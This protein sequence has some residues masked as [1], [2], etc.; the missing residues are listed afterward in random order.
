MKIS[1]RKIFLSFAL[2]AILC[3]AMI[4]SS[5]G[6]KKTEYIRIDSF[7]VGYL[8]ESAYNY[9][10]YEE[11]AI[12]SMIDLTDG[13]NG[14]MIVDFSYTILEDIGSG[15]SI[16]LETTFPGRGVLDITIEEAPTSGVEETESTTGTTL[17][18]KFSI[19]ENE[20]ESKAV[21][22]ILR[23]MPVSGGDVDFK[24]S[25]KV[26][27][28]TDFDG[29]SDDGA[30]PDGWEVNV[31]ESSISTGV[32]SIVYSIN[33]DGKSYTVTRVSR[34]STEVIIPD[35]LSDGLPV[36]AVGDEAFKKCINLTSI[37]VGQ[38]VTSIG[39]SV[40]SGCEKLTS[41]TIPDSVT[42]IGRD[43]FSYCTSL[44]SITIPNSV[45]SI[46]D[47]AFQDCTSLA[48][49]TIGNG[50]KSIGNSA[51]RDCTSLASVTIPDSVTSI[52]G[53]AFRD[54]TSLASVTIPDSVTSIGG[55]AF[56]DCTSLTSITIPDSITSIGNYAFR[57][58]TSLTSITIPDS[59]TSIGN[60]AFYRCT[61]LTSITIPNS[62]KSIGDSAFRSCTSLTSITIPNSVKSIGNSAFRDCTSLASVTIGNGVTS[63]GEDAFS[64]CTSLTKINYHGTK[65][66]WNAISKASD[67]NYNTGDYTITYNYTEE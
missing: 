31:I 44:T 15:K 28:G 65:A 43:A 58:C 46:G 49:V 41:I 19:Q 54:C 11:N 3:A 67:W 27:A 53:S 29:D 20:G 42:S 60:Y 57:S 21:R 47:Y 48:S 18:A 17:S 39:G 1:L 63:I 4:L 55:S 51:F 24:L 35:V 9:G 59:V 62:V 33:P 56:Q 38:N 36:T 40:F 23:L 30:I 32:P 2:I 5:C 61:S 34:D 25:L 52:G 22:V 6:D 50:V 12:V 66:Q 10:E 64:Y 13:R 37:I 8:T 14:Y 16:S 26:N 7:T 45:K